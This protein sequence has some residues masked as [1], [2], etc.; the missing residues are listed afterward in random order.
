MIEFLIGFGGMTV[1]ALGVY[2]GYQLRKHGIIYD[3]PS[4]LAKAHKERHT[5]ATFISE[6]PL[7]SN[8]PK[9]S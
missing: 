5:G 4:D 6:N 1:F 2:T 8:W 7:Y 3:R 9:D